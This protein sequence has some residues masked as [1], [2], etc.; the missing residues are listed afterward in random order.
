MS[1]PAPEP[2][3]TPRPFAP[4]LRQL[5]LQFAATLA[6]LSLA[7]PYYGIRNEQLPW[8]QTATAIGFVA[9]M[10]ATLTHQ[11]WWWRLMHALF[12]PLVW[13]ASTLHIDPG[14]YLLLFIALLLV[15]RGALGGQIPL[16]LSNAPT[17]AALA[18][19]TSDLPTMHFL[20]LGSGIGSIVV[21]LAR[22]RPQAQFTGVENAPATWAVGRLR[23]VALPNCDW[24]WGNIWRTDLSPYN[25]V[26]AFLSPAPMAALWEKVQREM[27]PGT[28]FISNSFAVPEVA[29]EHIVEVQGGRATRLYCY[30]R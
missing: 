27:R 12:A 25:V 22:Q 4:Q 24:R 26:Y 7:W 30:Q 23:T 2:T 13:A 19:I 3:E 1:S 10:L 17:V 21:P 15:Y 29:A 18:E 9:L 6:V 8:P 5:A 20:D 16:Y 28:L 14:W 11:P